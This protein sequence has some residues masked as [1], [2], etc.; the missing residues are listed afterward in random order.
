MIRLNMNMVIIYQTLITKL[1]EKNQN[2]IGL[3]IYQMQTSLNSPMNLEIN[4]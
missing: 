3:K 4:Q 2:Q 1:R